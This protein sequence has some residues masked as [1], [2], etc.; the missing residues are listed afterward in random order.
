VSAEELDDQK[1]TYGDECWSREQ[2]IRWI[3]HGERR[4]R[5]S[6]I[7]T[8]WLRGGRQAQGSLITKDASS[9]ILAIIA[10]H[11][12]A[13]I[14]SDSAPGGE[15]FA[16]AMKELDQKTA[17]TK[18]LF[19]KTGFRKRLVVK[20]WPATIGG[21]PERRGVAKA[22]ATEVAR[23]LSKVAPGFRHAER[24]EIATPADLC[25]AALGRDLAEKEQRRI[26]KAALRLS[27]QLIGD[28]P[29]SETNKH[30]LPAPPFKVEQV[31][32]QLR[33]DPKIAENYNLSD[34]DREYARTVRENIT[35]WEQLCRV[36]RPRRQ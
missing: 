13:W 16:R 34:G 22:D 27:K 7:A 10:A 32:R 19:Y 2:T 25:E 5:Y 11:T 4:A 36:G 35:L 15:D 26:F 23:L 20:I 30:C 21:R 31:F 29:I 14:E 28:L 8:G 6:E 17:T 18:G 12:S 1:L 24:G 33:A 9:E 3:A